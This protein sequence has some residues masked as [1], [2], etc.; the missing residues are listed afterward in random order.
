VRL[1][2][3]ES[4]YSGNVERNVEYARRCMHDCLMRNEAPIA[5]HLLYTQPGVLDD[6]KVEQR[7][8]GMIAGWMWYKVVDAVVVYDDLGISPGMLEGIEKAQKLGKI[9]EYRRIL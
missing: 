3:L 9:I 8:L 4:P 5:S 6:K 1:V 2:V 7:A